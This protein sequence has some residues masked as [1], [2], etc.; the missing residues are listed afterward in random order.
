[1]DPNQPV[2]EVQTMDQVLAQSLT[3]QRFAMA[4]LAWFAALALVL[5]SIGIYSVLAYAV[6]KR[7]REIA[8]RMALGARSERV[9][10]MIVVQGMRPALI[11]MLLGLA[12]A[13]ALRKILESLL[14]DVG[15]GDPWTLGGVAILLGLVSAAACFVPAYRASR[16]DPMAALRSE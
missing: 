1:V 15:V 9:A 7:S 16:I 13:I 14:Y 5:A 11:G 2:V 3:R 6:R 10:R 8:I 4:L 12:G